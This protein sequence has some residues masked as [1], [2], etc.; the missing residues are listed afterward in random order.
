MASQAASTWVSQQALD[1]QNAK[2]K[3]DALAIAPYFGGYLGTPAQ[4]TLVQSMTLDALFTELQTV[5]VPEAIGW[6]NA[7]APVASLRGV[8]LI[9]YEGGQHLTGVGGVENNAAIN[10]LFDSA[11]RDPRMGL[12]TR[13]ISTRGRPPVRRYLST[14]RTAGA[15]RSG[16]AGARWSISSSRAPA[17]RSLTRANLHRAEPGVVVTGMPRR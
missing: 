8:P 1:F 16:D 15:T 4:Q 6:I 17:R 5:A 13:P 12:F 2:L 3:T 7:Q 10:A 14:G 9:A 11:N